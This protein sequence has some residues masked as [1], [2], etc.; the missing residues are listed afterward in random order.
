MGDIASIPHRCRHEQGVSDVEVEQG[1][2]TDPGFGAVETW[3]ITVR[4]ACEL[5]CTELRQT[6]ERPTSLTDASGV[7]LPIRFV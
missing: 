7:P 2:V 4:Y 3:I 5:G 1:R 6:K